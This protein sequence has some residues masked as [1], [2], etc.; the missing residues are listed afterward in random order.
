MA[1]FTV[2]VDMGGTNLRIAGY[3]SE[4]QRLASIAIPTRVSEGPTAVLQDMAAGIRER[5]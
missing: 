1:K 5:D 3:G 4:W 2:G